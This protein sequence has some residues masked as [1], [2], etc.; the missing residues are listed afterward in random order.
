MKAKSA[1]LF[2][3]LSNPFLTGAQNE[4]W[5]QKGREATQPHEMIDFFTKSLENEGA[6]VCTYYYLGVA[7]YDLKDFRGAVDDFTK[8]IN[9]ESRYRNVIKLRDDLKDNPT[10]QEAVYLDQKSDS[11][12]T[13][14]CRKHSYFNRGNA[15][16]SLQNYQAAIDDYTHFIPL[17][18]DNL[19]YYN[20]RCKA[21][22]LRS[23]SYY[24]MKK[25]DLAL[26]D[27]STYIYLK[28]YDPDGYNNRGLIYL[29]LARYDDAIA[30]FN[31]TLRLKPAY[32]SAY[33]D[34]G[35]AYMQQRKM[36]LAVENFN[37]C[38][39][40]DTNTYST[41]LDLAIIDYMKG[42]LVGSKKYLKI[43]RTLEPLLS[44]GLD[45]INQLEKQGY[46]WTDEDKATLKRMFKKLK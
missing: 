9:T 27:I 23:A 38:L 10:K 45:G 17:N 6:S 41:Y 8:A 21:Y 34:I 12:D 29:I 3:I 15:N 7:K 40:I 26:D 31:K 36:D 4:S 33:A 37:Y 1:L 2:C 25:F 30:E 24:L 35:Y 14:D 44:K 22:Y 16:Y 13:E 11:T 18:P 5:Y 39:K 32:A 42:N 46:Y 43:S 19:E 20:P 28:P